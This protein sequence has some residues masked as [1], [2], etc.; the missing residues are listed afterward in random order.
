[1]RALADL[2]RSDGG[3]G[4]VICTAAAAVLVLPRVFER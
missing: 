3:A 4:Q 2:V 1:L